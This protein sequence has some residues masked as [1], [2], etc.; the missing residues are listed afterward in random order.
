MK[1]NT[2]KNTPDSFRIKQE[3]EKNTIIKGIKLKY[4]N[5]WVGDPYRD[6][7]IT[8]EEMSSTGEAQ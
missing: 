8:R 3:T 1:L 2:D 5:N 4:I 7:M 6:R